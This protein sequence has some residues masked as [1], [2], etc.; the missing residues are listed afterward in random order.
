MNYFKK[1]NYQHLFTDLL[2]V[3]FSSYASLYLRVNIAEAAAFLPALNKMLPLIVIYRCIFF[4]YFGTQNI[5]WRYVS[6]VDAYKIAKSIVFST[7]MI[8]ATTYIFDLSRIPRSSYFIDAFLC[9]FL[10]CSVRL[11]RRLYHEHTSKKILYSFGEKTLIYGAGINGQWLLKRLALDK[12]LRMY[13]VGFIDDSPLKI[14]KYISGYKVF[15]SIDELSQLIHDLEIKQVVVSIPNISTASL[16][17]V[18]RICSERGLKPLI[19]NGD[20]SSKNLPVRKIELKDL[21]TRK[22]HVIDVSSTSEMLKGK[23]VLITGA[24]GSIGS[25]ISR[26]VFNFQPSRLIILDH[27]EYN[28]YNIDQELQSSSQYT[29]IV[30]PTLVDVKDKAALSNIV[31][32][33]RPDIIIHAAAYKHVHLVESN[34]FTSILNNILGTKNLL[35]VCDEFSIQNF[36]L[37]STDKAV[38]PAGI[39]GS[40][41]RVCEILTTLAGQKAGKRYCAVRFGNVLGSSGS[42]IPLL[43]SQIEKG[44]PLTITHKEITRYFMLIEEAVALVLKAASISN[45]GDVNVLKMGDPIKIVDIAKTLLSLMGKT[46][47]EIPFIFTGLRPGEKMFEELYISGKELNTEHPDILVL[48]KGDTAENCTAEEILKQIDGMIED[49]KQSRKEAVYSLNALVNSNYKP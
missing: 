3:I 12:D 21:L 47:E 2:I 44:Q 14:G 17:K 16:K 42:L 19:M 13:A 9:V 33:Y 38:N 7:L 32:E 20:P 23:K 39:M 10:L 30:V 35:K 48:P 6:A 25:E 29:E 26:Q 37:I 11:T 27:S 5:I 22:T 18:I 43:K 45:P 8:I 1:I 24:G 34:P 28:L 49:A 31:Q 15:G 40:T 4:F 46:E 41:K 36:V